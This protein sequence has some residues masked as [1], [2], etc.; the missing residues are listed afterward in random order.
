M[1]GEIGIIMG[2]RRLVPARLRA[3]AVRGSNCPP[4]ALEWQMTEK[5]SDRDRK[6]SSTSA[7]QTES[8]ARVGCGPVPL[9]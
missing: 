6:A 4:R 7:A 3:R 2:I 8:R 9:V 5:L 1:F